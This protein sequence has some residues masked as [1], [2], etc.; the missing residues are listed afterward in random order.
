[1]RSARR[2]LAQC[3]RS[4]ATLELA[5]VAPIMLFA[6]MAVLD[7]T[8]A[9]LTNQLVYLSAQIISLSAA[10]QAV[11]GIAQGSST[12]TLTPTQARLAMTAVYGIIPGLK[13]TTTPYGVALAAITFTSTT[14]ANARGAKVSFSTT[15]P[16]TL[17]TSSMTSTGVKRPCGS[18]YE[19]SPNV[20]AVTP[21]GYSNQIAT[22]QLTNA[23]TIVVADVYYRYQSIFPIS[24]FAQLLLPAT[25]D[26]RGSFLY[27]VPLPEPLLGIVYDPVNGVAN[28]SNT[29]NCP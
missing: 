3:R 13:T 20:T 25:I 17:G 26:F 4:I 27:P 19:T 10:S 23:S 14:G 18:V 12:P 5:V 2:S 29:D 15:L 6:T 8:L 1:M 28:P 7:V 9:L 24:R 22:A 11:S 21:S 16:S